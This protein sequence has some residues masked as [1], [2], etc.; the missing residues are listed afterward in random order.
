VYTQR[1]AGVTSTNTVA[2]RPVTFE[3]KSG[4]QYEPVQQSALSRKLKLEPG[5]RYRILNAPTGYLDEPA[6]PADGS[7]AAADLVL[8]FA[9]NR[10][11]LEE[12]RRRSA[13]DAEAWGLFVD[14]ISEVRPLGRSDLNRKPRRGGPEQKLASSQRRTSAWTIN[15][16]Q[17][18]FGQRRMYRTLR[19]QRPTC[20]P[21]GRRATPTFRVVRSV[22]RALFHLALPI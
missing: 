11:Q 6:P 15:G 16:M 13:Q 21:V 20:L 19:F 10:A 3:C 14:R 18:S 9:S 2:T 17:H 8:L 22:A 1:V 12:K 7:D 4:A 5:A